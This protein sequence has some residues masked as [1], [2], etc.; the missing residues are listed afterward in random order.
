MGRPPVAET[1]TEKD[2]LNNKLPCFGSLIQIRYPW[3]DFL[4]TIELYEFYEPVELYEKN[5]DLIE[6]YDN[7]LS[8][9][10][11]VNKN[12]FRIESKAIQSRLSFIKVEYYTNRYFF[13]FFRFMF[14]CALRK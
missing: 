6:V 10:S 11:N 3:L 13:Q 14:S 2:E 7:G 4:C 8:S 1:E 9:L 5:T 12:D